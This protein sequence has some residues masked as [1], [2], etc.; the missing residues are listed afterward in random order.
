MAIGLNACTE[1]ENAI[2]P[3]KIDFKLNGLFFVYFLEGLSVPRR[4]AWIKQDLFGGMRYFESGKLMI[5][6]NYNI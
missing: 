6:V 4:P 2:S 5:T 1:A 3:R